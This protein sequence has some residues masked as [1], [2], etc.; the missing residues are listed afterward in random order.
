MFLRFFGKL[1]TENVGISNLICEIILLLIEISP[2]DLSIMHAKPT[3]L[4]LLFSINLEHSIADFPVVITS[5]TI[6]TLLF[7]FYFKTSS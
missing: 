5:S 3:I 4:A 6:R 7:F 1:S 2:L